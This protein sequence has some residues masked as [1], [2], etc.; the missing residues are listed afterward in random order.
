MPVPAMIYATSRLRRILGLALLSFLAAPLLFARG[1]EPVLRIPL[2]SLG[3][4]PQSA[5][6]LQAGSSLLTLH[7][8]DNQH[9]LLTFGVHRLME[10]IAD[11][12]PGD[13]DHTVEAVLL[14]VPSGRV[15]ARIDWRM[16]DNGQYLWGLGHGRFMLRTRDTLTTFAP[17]AN[18]ASGRP[19]YQRPFLTTT[20]R[21]GAL[22]LA[23]ESDLL[24]VES[25][26]RTPPPPPPARVLFGPTP[27]PTPAPLGKE[28]DTRP[29]ALSFYRLSL[30]D[31]GDEVIATLAGIA[32][33][34]NFGNIAATGAGHLAVVDQG[35][36]QWVFDFRP[37]NGEAKELAPFDST[38]SPTPRFV[39][40]SQFIAFGCH[41]GGSPHVLGG[42]NMRG[43]EMWEQ[44]LFGDFV[45]TSFAYAPLSGRFAMGRVLGEGATDDLQTVSATSLNGQSVVVYQTESGKQLLRVDCSP[46]VRAGQNFALS[47]DGM[48]LAVIRENAI[49]IYGLPP[50]SAKDQADLKE[51]RAL[52]PVEDDLPIEFAGPSPDRATS[53]SAASSSSDE[54]TGA[55]AAPA[56]VKAASTDVPAAVSVPASTPAPTASQPA[57]APAGDAAPEA[58][59]KRPTLYTLP[60]DPAAEGPK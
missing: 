48:N 18:L 19:F 54:T 7:Y 47:P 44:N 5:Q 55:D 13:E 25:V 38:C 24:V 35:R 12:P 52:V 17:L 21:I 41:S 2:D 29:V 14:E 51:A 39:S 45:A 20:R 56:A 11:D 22:L 15:L 23:P 57:T 10:R 3:F 31:L 50:L 4:Q 37:Y 36:Q 16:H 6:F 26:E 53:P 60:G 9:L 8:V 43:E 30:P 49:G 42:F 46:V 34:A 40:N 58:H 59:R 32:R 33:S 28:G 27:K 1:P